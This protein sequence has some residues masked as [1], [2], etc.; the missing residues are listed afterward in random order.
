VPFR[1]DFQSFGIKP[2]VHIA[3][4]GDVHIIQGGEPSQ[5]RQSPASTRPAGCADAHES[6][7]HL[8]VGPV[9]GPRIR[10]GGQGSHGGS[11]QETAA[12]ER[13]H[14]VSPR[15][16]IAVNAGPGSTWRYFP[17]AATQ[18]PPGNP[19]PFG[20]RTKEA[21]AAFRQGAECSL[22]LLFAA[23]A[24]L[25]HGQEGQ[26]RRDPWMA[27]VRRLSVVRA[28]EC[29]PTRDWATPRAVR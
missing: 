29:R 9:G 16:M 20:R 27:L 13:R 6:K 8:L 12:L 22:G 25:D 26:V 1:H 7:H 14:G 24:V 3:H 17:K 4:P 21:A 18:P 28:S 10:E 23:Q 19:E 2:L 15:Q 5:Q 11:L